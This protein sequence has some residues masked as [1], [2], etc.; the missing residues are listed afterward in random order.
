MRGMPWEELAM[1]RRTMLA[2]SAALPLLGRAGAA[3]G[4]AQAAPWPSRSVRWVMPSAPGGNPDILS[5]LWAQKLSERLGQ[6]VVVENRPGASGIIGTEGAM[7]SAP[8]GYT[9]LFGYNQLVTLN[10][11]LFRRLPYDRDRMTRVALMSSTPYVMLLHRSIPA[12]T[13]PEMVAFAKANPGRIAHGTA[14]PGT[15]SHL[16]GELL[17]RAA[18][19]ELLHVPHRQTPRNELISG[20][21]QLGVEPMA[22]A[23]TLTQGPDPQV[24]ALALTGDRPEPTMPGV[25]LMR[26]FFP[27][28]VVTA[29]HGLW[30]P[31]GMAREA[32]EGMAAAIAAVAQDPWLLDRMKTLGTRIIGTGPATLEAAMAR[33]FALWAPVVQ[34]KGI[35]LD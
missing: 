15:F 29:F 3:R 8:D 24:R 31:P 9:M 2:G 18:G 25:P 30:G 6:P 7:N 11:L 33:D 32:V 16:T 13:I 20:Q 17:M 10:P 34:E 23:L 28:F 21:V 19:I 14:G 27:G 26:D 5:R 1:R 4:Q 22:L 12:A 35:T